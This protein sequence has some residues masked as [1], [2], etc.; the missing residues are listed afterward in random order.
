MAER[1]QR[2]S[3]GAAMTAQRAL[4]WQNLEL[5]AAHA[6]LDRLCLGVLLLDGRGRLLHANRSGEEILTEGDGLSIEREELRASRPNETAALRREIRD[7][8]RFELGAD[9]ARDLL[10]S[11]PSGRRA[12]QVSVSPLRRDT[13]AVRD[14]AHP[15]VFVFVNDP[16][17]APEL[18]EC[19]L[20]RL[21]TLTLAEARMAH[22]LGQGASVAEAAQQ[23]GI[24]I[25]SARKRLQILFL[26]TDTHRQGELMKLL[27]TGPAV[28]R[29]L[30]RKAGCI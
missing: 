22:L 10:I 28:L 16:E 12:L 8:T 19:H 23:L 24:T 18:T 27:L 30:T 17:R 14:S 7:A 6:A 29:S 4:E 1:M 15:A 20:Q 9:A 5:N 25:A 3:V 26:K 2:S 21:Y 13:D 11:R